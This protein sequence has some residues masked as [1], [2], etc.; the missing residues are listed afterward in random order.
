MDIAF[1]RVRKDVQVACASVR[2]EL[3]D[4]LQAI[5]E[6]SRDITEMRESVAQVE[7]RVEQLNARIDELFLLLG[8][9]PSPAEEA[10]VAYL[11]APRTLAEMCEFTNKP[12]STVEHLLRCLQFRGV[13][14]HGFE[15]RYTV[16]RQAIHHQSLQRFM[17]D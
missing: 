17:T 1:W 13:P 8:A 11:Q 4:H 12:T 9:E 7:D 14:L 10:L 16:N 2:E 5:N 15:G 6:N 3:D